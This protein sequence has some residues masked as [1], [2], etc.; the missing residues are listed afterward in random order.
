M[1]QGW[2]TFERAVP[3]DEFLADASHAASWFP[4]WLLVRHRG[5]A[6]VFRADDIPDAPTD[7]AG[8][9]GALLALAPLEGRGLSDELVARR[10]ALRQLS[11]GFFRYYIE[12][13]GG[14]RRGG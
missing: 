13:V 8:A 6:H 14:R 5:L 1:R 4:A 7:A 11:P 10:R 9:F 12:I 2:E 3:V